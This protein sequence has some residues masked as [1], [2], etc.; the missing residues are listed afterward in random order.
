M[1]Y[2]GHQETRQAEQCYRVRILNVV[3]YAIC[4]SIQGRVV[5]T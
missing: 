5:A 2:H 4:Y 1:N 3:K